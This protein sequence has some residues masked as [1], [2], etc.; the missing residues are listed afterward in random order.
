MLGARCP[1][2]MLLL[3]ERSICPPWWNDKRKSGMFFSMPFR[4]FLCSSVPSRW[5]LLFPPIVP[6]EFQL[7][8]GSEVAT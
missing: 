8:F 2:G 3:R 5:A 1:S 6:S 4:K 7:V